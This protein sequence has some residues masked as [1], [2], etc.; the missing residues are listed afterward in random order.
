MVHPVRGRPAT[1][2]SILQGIRVELGQEAILLA[3]ILLAAIL[4]AAI[5]LEVILLEGIQLVAILLEG[6]L[7][8]GILLEDILGGTRRRRRR[9]TG[10]NGRTYKQVHSDWPDLC[11]RSVRYRHHRL[12]G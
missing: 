6:I 2:P 3:A 8:E 12:P 11:S 4:P 7:L 5:L 1:R 9:A 10:R